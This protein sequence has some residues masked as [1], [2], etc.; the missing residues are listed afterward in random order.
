MITY[1]EKFEIIAVGAG[2]AGCHSDFDSYK[3]RINKKCRFWKIEFLFF[4]EGMNYGSK[5]FK[6]AKCNK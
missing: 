3:E 4:E 2:H 1:E 5:D 6:K